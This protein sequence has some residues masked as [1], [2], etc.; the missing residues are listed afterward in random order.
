MSLVE[1]D[2]HRAGI[3]CRTDYSSS[4]PELQADAGLL[5]QALLNL[6]LNACQA[7][8]DGGTLTMS[9]RR[10]KGGQVILEVED[11]GTGIARDQLEKIF[12][13]YYTTKPGGSGIG[14][15]MVYRIAHLHGGE[16]EVESTPGRGTRFRLLL[17]QP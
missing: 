3:L 16:V 11:T 14:L 7:M 9:A 8:P 13:L 6:A 1:P 17:P 2:I 10:G 15:S 5:R 12:D 4:L